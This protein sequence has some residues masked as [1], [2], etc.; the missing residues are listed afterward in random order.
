MST[1]AYRGM[2]MEGWVARWY[3]ANARKGLEEYQALA[4]RMADGLALGAS[5]LEVAS[6]PGFFAIEISKLG[7]FQVTGLDISKTLLKM[8]R[9]NAAK[10]GVR[11]DFCIGNVATL[12]F[13]A[14][15][16]DF[17]FC[18]AAFNNFREPVRAL[19]EMRRALRSGG[20]AVILDLRRD[21]AKEALD[22]YIKRMRLGAANSLIHKLLFR[23][24]L[25]KRAYT[26]DRL[27]ELIV[28]SGFTSSWIQETPPGFEISLVK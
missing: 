27:R 19:A 17:I 15:T 14:E 26:Q 13:T 4:R 1:K 12:P 21:A 8:A 24:I 6:G 11:V 2:G 5:V 25:V 23:L 28:E 20:K 3:A 9:E 7:K 18:C 10:E 22:A 16:F